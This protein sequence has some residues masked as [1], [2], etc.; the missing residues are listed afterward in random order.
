[1]TQVCPNSGMCCLQ[2]HLSN[3]RFP[4]RHLPLL[5]IHEQLVVWLDPRPLKETQVSTFKN[6]SVLT[7]NIPLI[8]YS[9]P[10][11]PEQTSNYN[12]IFFLSIL[13][14]HL[15]QLKKC[16]AFLTYSMKMYKLQIKL[17]VYKCMCTSH[18]PQCTTTATR[19][20]MRSGLVASPDVLKRR[21]SKGKTTR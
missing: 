14:K 3:I 15:P 5:S 10:V 20:Y 12:I 21:S 8:C 7:I 2:S 18:L 6:C 11:Q 9:Q 17:L 4:H 19:S 1:M 13:N 16:V